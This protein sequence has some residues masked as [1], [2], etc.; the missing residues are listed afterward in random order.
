MVIELNPLT[1]I[2]EVARAPFLNQIPPLLTWLTVLGI[3]VFGWLLAFG[4]FART[5]V[6][7]PYWL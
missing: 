2:L 4:L 3:A 5:R 6:R 7:I 1:H